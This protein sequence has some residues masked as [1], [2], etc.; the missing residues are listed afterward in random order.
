M[1][2]E[3]L[4]FPSEPLIFLSETL[5]ILEE[6]FGV[7]ITV[8]DCFGKLCDADG[9]YLTGFHMKHRHPFCLHMRKE[10]EHCNAQCIR[11]C[12]FHVESYAA[13]QKTPFLHHCWK[14]AWELIVPVQQNGILQFVFYAGVFRAEKEK[15][16]ESMPES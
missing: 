2:F 10:S 5:R 16:P 9:E 4:S 14:G 13:K 7:V 11:N 15:P 1:Y 8:H 12:L 3:N 6:K